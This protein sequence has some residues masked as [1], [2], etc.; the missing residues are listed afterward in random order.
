MATEYL[1]RV[2]GSSAININT[3]CKEN[4]FEDDEVQCLPTHPKQVA[5]C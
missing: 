3:D 2:A 4:P 1:A 5:L